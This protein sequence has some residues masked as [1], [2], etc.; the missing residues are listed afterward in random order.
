VLSGWLKVKEQDEF[1][2]IT[3]KTRYVVVL[4]GF[5]YIYMDKLDIPPYGRYCKGRLCLGGYRVHSAESG[6][7]PGGLGMGGGLSHLTQ[8]NSL[9]LTFQP[10][11]TKLEVLP[12]PSLL[13]P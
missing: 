2:S 13:C 12:P 6:H 1:L 8:L 3:W 4:R 7:T 11:Q 5:L 9:H 10:N